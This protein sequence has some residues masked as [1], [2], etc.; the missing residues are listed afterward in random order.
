MANYITKLEQVM[1]ALEKYLSEKKKYN[2]KTLKDTHPEVFK[3]FRIII[4]GLMEEILEILKNREK[5]EEEIEKLPKS[6]QEGFLSLLNSLYDYFKKLE[7]DKKL[8]GA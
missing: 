7:S 3:E 8:I 5:V 4:K 6:E 2:L 1:K